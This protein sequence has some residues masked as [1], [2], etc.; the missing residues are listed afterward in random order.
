MARGARV[1][2]QVGC[3]PLEL[4]FDVLGPCFG[5]ENNSFWRPLL[6]EPIEKRRATFAAESFRA[7]LR[8]TSEG[9]KALL[10][11]SWECMFLRVP[12][13]E[14]HRRF[15]DTSVA[16]IARDLRRD[17]ED[18][19]ELAAAELGDG[20][21]VSGATHEHAVHEAVPE[22][23]TAREGLGV[24]GDQG[25]RHHHDVVALDQGR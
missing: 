15:A 4:R 5:L 13:I 7:R 6:H 23:E 1:V 2:P 10:T 19:G 8:E 20:D 22:H 9:W 14:E 17:P 18:V 16:G 25:I 21:Q 11:P 24:P 12:A 3:R